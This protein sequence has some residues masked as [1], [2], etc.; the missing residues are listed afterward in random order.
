[1]EWSDGQ[2]IIDGV[3]WWQN[4][5]CGMVDWEWSWCNDGKMG[6]MM[7]EMMVVKWYMWWLIEVK[8]WNGKEMNKEINKV[9]ER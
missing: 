7:I 1:M 5:G 2:M 3:E 6:K 4:D 8:W 9:I